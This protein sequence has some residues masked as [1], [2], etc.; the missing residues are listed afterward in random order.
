MCLD[1]DLARVPLGFSIVTWFLVGYEA[2]AWF[3]ASVLVSG[4]QDVG[5]AS[6]EVKGFC[7]RCGLVNGGE[8]R[9]GCGYV[10]WDQAWLGTYLIF[11][12]MTWPLMG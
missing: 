2:S 1:S 3:Y 4:F 10:E 11:K 5:L 7:H 6:G 9:G 12:D 8:K